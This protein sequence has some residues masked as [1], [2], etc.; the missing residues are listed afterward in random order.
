[1]IR[2]CSGEHLRLYEVHGRS[3]RK[4]LKEVRKLLKDI[5]DDGQPYGPTVFAIDFMLDECEELYARVM[6]SVA[7][8]E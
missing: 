3:E 6:L 1:M 4:I 7:T 2:H 8:G 5:K